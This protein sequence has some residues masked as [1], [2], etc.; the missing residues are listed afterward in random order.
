ML[1]KQQL[2]NTYK[3]IGVRKALLYLS[4]CRDETPQKS[5]DR[6]V[7]LLQ[8]A[9]ELKIPLDS[10]KLNYPMRFLEVSNHKGVVEM[11]EIIIQHA[12]LKN[13][14]IDFKE[15]EFPIL[16][17]SAIESSLTR[18]YPIILPQEVYE[19]R[20]LKRKSKN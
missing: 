6:F 3:D 20:S 7:V 13:S 2:I 5:L 10:A 12:R 15:V 9:H 11:G 8:E 14:W 1:N 17:N 16:K 19:F 4:P 18:G